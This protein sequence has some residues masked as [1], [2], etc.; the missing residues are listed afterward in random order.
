MKVNTMIQTAG[1]MGA[2]GIMGCNSSSSATALVPVEVY[3]NATA[4]AQLDLVGRY[5]SGKTDFDGGVME[6]VSYNTA[7]GYAYA[8]NG[9]SGELAILEM[10]QVDGKAPVS[11]TAKN[12]AVKS[13]VEA[14]DGSFDYGDMTSIA[15]S[16][17]GSKLAVALQASDYNGKGR[18]AIFSCAANG[19]L[20]LQSVIAGG[21]QPDMLTF[22]GNNTILTANEGEP[23]KTYAKEDPEGSISIVDIA[24]KQSHKV[25]FTAYD[26]PAARQAL[27]KKGVLLKKGAKPS[28]DF[29]PEYIAVVGNKAFVSLQEAN[30]IAVVDIAAKKVV[31]V[32]S[33]GFVDY[34][35][36]KIDLNSKDKACK[37]M[38]YPGVYGMRMADTIAATT[39]GGS[40]YLLTA[41]EGDGRK[42]GKK[43]SLSYYKNEDKRNFAKDESSPAG[44]M[45]KASFA[46]AKVGKVTFLDVGSTEGIKAGCDY[47]YGG[48]GF[49]IYRVSGNNISLVYDSGSDFERITAQVL[50]KYY[51][52]SNDTIKLDDRSGKKGPEPECVTVG[53]IGSR[54]YAFIGLERTGGVMMYDISQPSSARFVNYINTR[55]FATKLRETDDDGDTLTVSGGDV[56]PESIAFIPASQSKTGTP[57]LLVAN[58]VSGTVAAIRIKPAK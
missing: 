57:L 58:E 52:A 39:I 14:M 24:T 41:N 45:T 2:L 47:V 7:N 28:L 34:G 8:I 42:L 16:P 25:G 31:N 51:N 19:G 49:S 38:N 1:L 54:T 6:I 56:A 10:S 20:S 46:A 26:A 32:E 33:M 43:K 5:V 15:L 23:R 40:T 37:L 4:A 53:K 30:A 48:R 13:A 22:A 55:D 21:V 36:T 44:R 9:K 50:P 29:E 12:F 17:D 18:V 35:K 11:I 27:V 3:Q